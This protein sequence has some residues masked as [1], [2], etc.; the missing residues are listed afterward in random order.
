MKII[1]FFLLFYLYF[2]LLYSQNIGPNIIDEKKPTTR[3]PN[4]QPPSIPYF[5]K[6]DSKINPTQSYILN[7]NLSIEDYL[8]SQQVKQKI[9]VIISNNEEFY[10][11]NLSD[12]EIRKYYFQKYFLPQ[13]GIES[14]KLDYNLSFLKEPKIYETKWERRFTIFMLSFPL[15]SGLNYGI[16]RNYKSSQGVKKGLDR[17]ETIG[18]FS[19]GAIFSF[20]IVYYDENYFKGIQSYSKYLKNQ[21]Y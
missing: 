9:P 5:L 10:L 4:Y 12:N 14:Q 1:K 11:Q 18:I 19:I 15:I 16:Y 8:K 21:N 3:F 6:K 13:L 20:F 2:S 17:N 7:P